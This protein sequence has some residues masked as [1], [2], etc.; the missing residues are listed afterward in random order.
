MN[1]TDYESAMTPPAQPCKD[2]STGFR[3]FGILT[4]LL[5][6]LCALFI[7]LM[8]FARQMAATQSH[9]ATAQPLSM[10][11]P[12][13]VMYGILAIALVWLGI[14]SVMVTRWA[15]ALI[16]LFSW[17][18]LLTGVL[19]VTTM[20]IVLTR[21]TPPATGPVNGAPAVPQQA[22][23]VGMIAALLFMSVIFIL[24][25]VIWILFYGNRNVKATCDAH[26]P[27]PSWTDACPLPVL[28]LCLMAVLSAPLGLIMPL[29]GHFAVPLFGTI[30]TGPMAGALSAAASALLAYAGWAM[31]RLK[32]T[33][34]WIQ[35]AI[36]GFYAA[37]SC[38]TFAHHDF[39]ELYEKMGYPQATIDQLRAN[40]FMQGNRMT[41]LM[42][43]LFIPVIGY[44]LFIKRYFRKTT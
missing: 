37:S 17:G 41:W 29:F 18:W 35:L 42:P 2:R 43:V 21:I 38:I 8:L 24:M 33:G 10:L 3:V 27:V 31:Y 15:R 40:P 6:F 20:A 22:M 39:V 1:T 7:P 13:L 30:L 36:F 11:L 16:L 44:L 34:W 9:G 26:N 23:M 14:G 12:G 5:G 19:S 28:A 4:I 25:P 32:V